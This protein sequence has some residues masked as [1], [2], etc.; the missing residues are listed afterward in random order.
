LHEYAN[1]DWFTGAGL[2]ESHPTI[3]I[4]KEAPNYR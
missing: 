2:G 4:T 3:T 1:F